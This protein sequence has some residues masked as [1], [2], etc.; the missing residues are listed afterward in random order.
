MILPADKGNTTVVMD[1]D[2]YVA[3]IETLLE[4]GT[5]RKLKKD[6]TSSV[7][8]K[9]CQALKECEKKGFM[10]QKQRIHLQQQFSTPPQLYGLPKVHKEGTPLRPIVSAIGSPTHS[11][12]RLLT[13]ILNPLAGQTDSFVNN[14]SHFAEKIKETEVAATDRMISFDVVS[15]FTKVPVEEALDA[16][17]QR[18]NQ[19]ETLEERTTLPPEQI[20]LLTS[21][22]LHSTYF[23]FQDSFFEQLEGAAMGSPL[24]PIIE[25]IF[26]EDLERKALEP[27]TL[28]PKMWLRY[29]DDTFVIWPH[30]EAE[31]ESF[32]NHINNQHTTIK[33]TKEEEENDCIPF[34][35]VLVSRKDSQLCTTVYHKPTHTNRYINY[36]SNHHPR[37][38]R[39]TLLCLKDRAH[40][41]CSDGSS[42]M[43]ENSKLQT[44]FQ[45]NGY[46][47]TRTR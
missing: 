26:M 7:E 14:S 32:H 28:K 12:A 11:V 46:L 10:D 42:R 37:V 9:I 21:L 25:K 29:V 31:L 23:Q 13:K 35:D 47:K 40:K 38:L 8:S 18:L 15:L 33:S 24:S 17:A 36:N 4:D 44:A 22:C 34:L 43:E 5:Y 3:K 20:C 39:S 27:L 19:D 16:I 1:K 2:E 45:A 6:P 30:S 41:I